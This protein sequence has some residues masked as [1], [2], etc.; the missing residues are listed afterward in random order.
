MH[1]VSE[2]K[3]KSAAESL[4]MALDMIENGTHAQRILVR[5]AMVRNEI[6]GLENGDRQ[7]RNIARHID[8]AATLAGRC[9][10]GHSRHISLYVALLGIH[11]LY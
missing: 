10:T 4:E 11:K 2:L 7:E 3:I 8:A 1:I 6:A 9:V 5:I